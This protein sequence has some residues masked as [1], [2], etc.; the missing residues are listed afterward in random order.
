MKTIS[1]TPEQKKAIK[2]HL[3]AFRKY[4]ASERFREDQKD[5]LSRVSYFQERLPER[6][7]ELSEADVNELVAMLWA[8]RMWGNKQYLAR[9]IIA[10]NGIEK[11]RRELKALLDTSAPVETR[12]ERFFEEIKGLGPASVTEMLCY[13]QPESCGI[14]NQKARQAFK[15][16]GL[17][18][19][20][21]AD[22]YRLSAGE[23]KSFN[24]VLRSIS[25]ELKAAGFQD[26][27]LLFVDYFLYQASQT[28]PGPPPPEEFDHDEVR[29][30]I[31]DI[32]VMLGFDADT[33]VQVAHGAKVDAVW[34]ARIGN[35]GMVTYVFEVHRLGSID[36][37]LLNLQKAKSSPTVQKVIAVSDEQ[38]LEKIEGESEGLPEEFRRAL[39][40]WRVNEVRRVGENLQSAMEIINR[41]GLGTF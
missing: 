6:V 13:I 37:L 21:N 15:V 4:A 39:G 11:L 19:Y 38:Q 36:S 31:R 20:V 24:Q 1:L 34:R 33:E 32:G 8:S 26:V 23:Y 9:K 35:L 25:E 5:R 14:W 16:L 29:D 22:K 12:Y 17:A 40:F 41:L 18:T 2:R 7:A 10:D 28:T 27:D 3:Q 30:L